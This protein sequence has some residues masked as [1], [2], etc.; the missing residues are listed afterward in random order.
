MFA[1]ATEIAAH[2]TH[3]LV[4]SARL[5][6]GRVRCAVGAFVVLNEDGWI[7]TAAHLLE[8]ATLHAAHQAEVAEHGAR[9]QEIAAGE[10]TAKGKAKRVRSLGAN[11]DWVRNYSLWTGW[12]GGSWPSSTS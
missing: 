2:Y 12:T 6:D 8:S 10:G 4:V 1:R 3:P 9:A 5:F 7:L 11:P